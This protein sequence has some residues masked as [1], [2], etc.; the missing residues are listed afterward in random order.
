MTKFQKVVATPVR[1]ASAAQSKPRAQRWA[2]LDLLRGLLL[3]GNANT[4]TPRENLKGREAF[5]GRLG[6]AVSLLL[7]LSCSS[8]L[9]DTQV[10]SQTIS[11]RN[12]VVTVSKQNCGA[13]TPFVMQVSGGRYWTTSLASIRVRGDFP[14]ISPQWSRD[15]KDLTI[16]L[17]ADISDEDLFVHERHWGDVK[18]FFVRQ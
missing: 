6:A 13:T 5:V 1:S 8:L 12:D 11:A 15:G 7:V 3:E 18:V 14:R 9:C 2:A 4:A 17:P 16:G 10:V